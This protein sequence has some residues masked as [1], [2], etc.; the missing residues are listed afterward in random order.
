MMRG[1]IEFALAALKGIIL[2]NGAAAIA[3]LAFLGNIWDPGHEGANVVVSLIK[4]AMLSFVVGTT[5]GIVASASSYLS[6]MFFLEVKNKWLGACF[7]I[8][9]VLVAIGGIVAFGLGA[10]WAVDAFTTSGPIP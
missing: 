10:V 4:P 7:R 1:V 8:L 9:A 2:I 5:A 3:I 6:Q